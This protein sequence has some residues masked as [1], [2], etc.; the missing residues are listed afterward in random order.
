MLK[1]ALR[2]HLSRACPEQDL[3]RW[4]DPLEVEVIE[5]IQVFSVQFPHP[6]FA[7]WFGQSVQD[8]FEKEVG[9]FMGGIGAAH[10]LPHGAARR[11]QGHAL[12]RFRQP[13]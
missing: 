9:R 8:L 11:D 2:Q 5:P 4:F 7:Q 3:K 12:H 13:Y 1:D 6:Y 10:P